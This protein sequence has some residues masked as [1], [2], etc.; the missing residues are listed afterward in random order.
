[1]KKILLATLIFIAGHCIGQHTINIYQPREIQRAFKNESRN[2]NGRPGNNYFQ[3][4]SDYTIDAEFFPEIN[5]IKG[6]E[7]ISYAN[8]SPDTLK[9]LVFNVFQNY[10]KQGEARD[11][12][13]DSQ[14]IHDGVQIQN[15][16]VNE[17]VY[18]V[19]ALFFTSTLMY[20]KLQTPIAPEALAII[21]LKWE[22]SLPK[23]GMYRQGTYFSDSYFVACW[24]P[25]IAFYDDI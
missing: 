7:T 3:N 13:I 18:D 15:L 1:M 16:I 23:T 6:N 9:Y 10:F 19:S 12:A 21:K 11:D 25:R 5:L 4:I 8:N 14:N 22:N 20:V 17:D 24:F 2:I